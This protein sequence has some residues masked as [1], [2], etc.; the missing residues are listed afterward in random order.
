MEYATLS[1]VRYE[2]FDYHGLGQLG[3]AY[4]GAKDDGLYVL[5]G[6]TDAG[7][8]ID[9]L[10]E[11]G[12]M[13]LDDPHLKRVVA[14]HF[15]LAAAGAIE[16]TLTTDATQ[17]SG[18]YQAALQPGLRPQRLKAKRGVKGRYWQTKLANVGGADL[19]VDALA[20]ETEVLKGRLK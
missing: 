2:A 16:L 6:D 1:P 8:A 7:G 13:D 15:G 5:D 9:A 17:T 19:A 4:L 3:D 18:P 20:L 12:L 10:A 11:T 14:A